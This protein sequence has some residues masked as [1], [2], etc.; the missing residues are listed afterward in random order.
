VRR[1]QGGTQRG[2]ACPV[3]QRAD[4][5]LHGPRL[6]RACRRSS[7]DLHRKDRPPAARC[8]GGGTKMTTEETLRNFILK[9]LQW[10]GSPAALTANFSLIDGKVLD[11][12]GIV[13]MVSFI[14]HEFNI[15]VNDEEIVP[16]NFETLGTLAAFVD[17]KRT[18]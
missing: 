7:E 10:E 16:R 12:L 9:D 15:K 8:W 11:S 18:S 3:L 14:E 1:G 4:P 2:R 13:Q 6:I 17:G 5:S